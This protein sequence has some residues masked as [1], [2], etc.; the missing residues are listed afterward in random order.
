M[1]RFV[2][3]ASAFFPIVAHAEQS[4]VWNFRDAATLQQWK[5]QTQGSVQVIDE[6][7]GIDAIGKE[8]S[9]YHPGF[10]HPVD[11]IELVIVAPVATP[12]LF[13]WHV[14]GTPHSELVQ[15]PFTIQPAPEPRPLGLDLSRY[16]QW[17]PQADVIGI[18]F[19]EGGRVL[20]AEVRLKHWSVTEKA[21]ELWRSYWTLDTFTRYSINFLWGPLLTTNR[22]TRETLFSQLPPSGKSINRYI[23]V[24][25]G[26]GLLT[27][28]I[29]QFQH[30]RKRRATLLSFVVLCAVLW[31]TYDLRMGVEILSYAKHDLDTFVRKPLGE[32][33]FRYMA[34]FHDVL[35]RALPRLREEERFGF[36]SDSAYMLDSSMIYMA[37]P[38]LPV[39]SNESHDGI[40]TW[41]VYMRSDVT[42]DAQGR[43]TNPDGSPATAPGKILE[44]YN[45]SSFLFTTAR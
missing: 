19:P 3:L 37:Y 36:L 8:T 9:L 4:T 25:M 6:G 1:W 34:D 14:R 24:V 30:D 43:L 42:V 44:R 35:E 16:N 21:A 7:L 20:I 41:L 18:V 33:T 17:D 5:V 10:P 23:Y 31:I 38:S 28:L 27:V 45:S 40:D 15:L 32:R 29:A 13:V 26:I 2:L 11:G 39:L 22:I 12:G